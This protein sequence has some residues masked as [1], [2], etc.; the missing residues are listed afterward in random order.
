MHDA[1]GSRVH[2]SVVSMPPVTASVRR[3]RQFGRTKQSLSV[4]RVSSTGVTVETR[5]EHSVLY[6]VKL[7]H[8]FRP[9]TNVDPVHPTFTDAEKTYFRTRTINRRLA[10]VDPKQWLCGANSDAGDGS[11]ART[12]AIACTCR[13]WEFRGVMH[14]ASRVVKIEPAKEAACATL[15]DYLRRG[16]TGRRQNRREETMDAADRGCKHMQWVT[17]H[18]SEWKE[19]VIALHP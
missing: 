11:R 18:P 12:V 1:C 15:H 7:G 8:R 13:D 16:G 2:I 9:D 14:A 10:R 17:K 19:R 4:K 3:R 5:G 6:C